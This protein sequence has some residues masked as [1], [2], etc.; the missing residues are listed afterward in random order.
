MGWFS[1]NSKSKQYTTVNE[2]TNVVNP[3]SS[4]ADQ[5][6]IFQNV[7]GSVNYSPVSTDQG[8]VSGAFDFAGN[9][10]EDAFGFANKVADYQ[11][12][13]VAGVLDLN[14]ELQANTSDLITHQADQYGDV[15]AQQGNTFADLLSSQSANAADSQARAVNAVGDAY[16]A[17]V[18]GGI[19]T[20]KILNTF[21]VGLFVVG[22]AWVIFG[23]KK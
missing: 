4:G 9:F 16:A 11:G 8:A 20:G 23:G 5:S 1:S 17:S 6:Q 12:Q 21:V 7:S 18:Q 3:V 2:T 19:N 13:T 22:G 14:Q 10:T 15:I